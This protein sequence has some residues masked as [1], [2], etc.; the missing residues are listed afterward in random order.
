MD[1]LFQIISFASI[2]ITIWGLIHAFRNQADFW[3]FLI[4]IFIPFGN[5]IYFILY[6]LPELRGNSK[7]KIQ[8]PGHELRLIRRLED[9]L[10]SKDTTDIRFELAEL[11]LKY[12]RPDDAEKVLEP[13]LD[14]PLSDSKKFRYLR[15]IVEI[16]QK[17]DY[18]LAQ[19]CL[20]GFE[21]PN[22]AF[23]KKERQLLQAR[24]WAATNESD[25]ADNWFQSNHRKFDGEEASFR[26]IEFLLENANKKKAAEV[27]KQMKSYLQSA[28]DIYKKQER[29]WISVAQKALKE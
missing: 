26:Y 11:Y 16:T 29:Y 5:L 19:Q 28:G 24:I 17:D 15:A 1:L 8:M 10:K 4:I 7:L 23:R 3:W 25:K 27:F 2:A 6:I 21:D 13:V 14:G 20:D 12:D 22:D 18:K 9:E